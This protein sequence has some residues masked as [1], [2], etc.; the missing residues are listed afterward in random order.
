M[1]N[2][3][4]LTCKRVIYYSILDEEM[5]FEWLKKIKC[6]SNIEGAKDELYLDLIDK[7]M[8]YEDMKNFI[9]IF[10]RYKIDMTQLA[11][12][13]NKYNIDAALPWQ[14]EICFDAKKIID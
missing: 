14:E 1:S 10:Y 2:Q 8:T 6:I 3:I 13:I 12:F 7:D 4:Y 9:A 11:K 5:F